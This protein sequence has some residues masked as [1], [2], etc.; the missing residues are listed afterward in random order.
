MTDKQPIGAYADITWND[1][2][3][4][5]GYY[6][7]FGDANVDEEEG[8]GGDWLPDSFGVPDDDI[9]FYCNGG[10]A[11]LKKY[12]TDNCQGFTV[13]SYELV[14]QEPTLIIHNGETYGV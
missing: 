2:D 4:T 8:M 7:S 13:R 3:M 11:E 1:G 9:F 5:D 14:Y 6:F 12:M 10:E